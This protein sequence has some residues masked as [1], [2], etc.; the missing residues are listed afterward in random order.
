MPWST[1]SLTTPPTLQTVHE[2]L[3][4][5]RT[6]IPAELDNSTARLNTVKETVTIS[7]NPVAAAASNVA[8]LRASMESLLQAGGRFV[9]VHPYIHPLGDRRGDYA[10]LTPQQAVEGMA[11][12]LA[13]PKDLQAEDELRGVF[14]LLRGVDNDD[15][16]KTL[17]AFNAVFPVTELQL[18]ERRADGLPP[19]RRTSSFRKPGRFIRHG[20]TKTRGRH[21]GT[22]R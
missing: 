10:Y 1:V 16:A 5:C 8:A 9:C 3:H 15:F 6:A 22:P 13:D 14:L 4:N 7:A 17:V 20:P 11:A 18:A 12:K 2:G 19:W 21:P